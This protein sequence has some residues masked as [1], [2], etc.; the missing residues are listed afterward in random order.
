MSSIAA[1]IGRILLAI[2][3]IVS[4]ATKLMNVAATEA[5]IT[6]V[7]MPGG[8]A[9]PTGLFELIVG[10]CIALGLMTR[11]ASILLAGFTLLAALLYHNRLDD[12][13]QSAMFLKD[14]AIAG[15]LLL[16]FAHSQ[17]WYGWD[18][19]R[20][21]RRHEVATHD[22]EA[23]VREAELRAA[24]AEGAVQGSTHTPTTVESAPR[25]RWF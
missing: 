7:G 15:G 12:P 25:R 20:R 17:I 18:R 2:I 22:A 9:I 8:L 6:G 23:R 19:I 24:R 10:I 1:V 5:M 16:V 14:V 21:D 11:I 3:F 4:G 13:M